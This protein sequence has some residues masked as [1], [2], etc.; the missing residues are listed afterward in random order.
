M[1]RGY[2]RTLQSK[3]RAPDQ[4]LFTLAG[5]PLRTPD[6]WRDGP[7]LLAFYK[8]SCPTCQLTLP[9]LERLRA[10]GARVFAI[11]QDKPSTARAFNTEFD[12]PDMPTLIDPAADGYP[13]SDAFGL[14]HVPSMF[15]VQPDG[16]ITWDSVGFVRIDLEDLSRRLDIPIFHNGD[17]VP[18]AKAG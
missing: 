11:A 9:F 18:A 3:D 8:A 7:A 14:T 16:V 13:A 15:L 2:Q 6:L 4:P 10:G 1:G 17:I 12:L 5:E